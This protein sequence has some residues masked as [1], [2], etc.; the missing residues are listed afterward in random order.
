MPHAAV[1]KGKPER[2]YQTIAMAIERRF[3]AVRKRIAPFS[4]APIILVG[5]YLL[6]LVLRLI[7][8]LL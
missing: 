8:R 4:A 5:Y 6:L 1:H 7:D 3:T 2:A